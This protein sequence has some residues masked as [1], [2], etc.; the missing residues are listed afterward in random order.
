VCD[1]TLNRFLSI[2]FLMPIVILGLVALH[3][4]YLH[5]DSS[6]KNDTDAIV[7]NRP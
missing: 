7:D 1:A 2:H 3:V 6:A 5:L 4:V